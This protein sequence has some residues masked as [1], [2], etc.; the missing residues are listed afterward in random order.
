[1]PVCSTDNEPAWRWKQCLWRSSTIE[2]FVIKLIHAK[3]LLGLYDHSRN[4]S[5]TIIK[6]F[7]MAGIKDALMMEL[8]LENPF[9]DLDAYRLLISKH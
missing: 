3:W 6:E 2:T 7:T 9:A 4:S 1:M 8:P 5:D